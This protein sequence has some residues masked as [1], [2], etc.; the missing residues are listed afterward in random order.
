MTIVRIEEGPSSTISCHI[1]VCL[2]E[3][4][5]DEDEMIPILSL[6]IWELRHD[7]LTVR[8]KIEEVLVFRE[9]R[10][11]DGFGCY[12]SIEWSIAVLSDIGEEDIARSSDTIGCSI[13][14]VG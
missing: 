6:G 7:I 13:H 3:S 8:S 2:R 1:T 5:T 4:L 11:V 14:I 10:E 12:E 9:I